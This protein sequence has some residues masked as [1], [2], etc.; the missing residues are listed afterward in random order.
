[1]SKLTKTAKGKSCVVCG[2]ED[3]SVVAAHYCG[4]RQLSLGKGRAVKAHDL[5]SAELCHRCHTE[6]MSEGKLP[7]LCQDKWEASE[8]RLH[9]CMLTN[10]RRFERGDLKC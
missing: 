8:V 7:P 6:W 5:D 4:P 9:L 2:V 3:G 1:M 10:I